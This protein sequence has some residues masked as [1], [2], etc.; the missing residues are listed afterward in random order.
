[1]RAPP[2]MRVRSSSQPACCSAL[3]PDQPTVRHRL[4]AERL[5]AGRPK[6]SPRVARPP[7]TS[8]LAAATHCA[9][10]RAYGELGATR[11]SSVGVGNFCQSSA[12]SEGAAP[13]FTGKHQYRPAL[14][15][16]R[17]ATW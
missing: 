10:L 1:M 15:S 16:T 13:V 2:G 5:L 7:P 14:Y 3:E 11:K 9:P 6:H 8:A 12:C 17:S 4:D